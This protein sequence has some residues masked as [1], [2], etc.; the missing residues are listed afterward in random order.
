MR[1]L[2]LAAAIVVAGM[3]SI[4]MAGTPQLDGAAACPRFAMKGANARKTRL[5]VYSSAFDRPKSRS[6]HLRIRLAKSRAKFLQRR[7]AAR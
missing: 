7:I 3:S 2:A 4:A 5:I 6:R 1:H